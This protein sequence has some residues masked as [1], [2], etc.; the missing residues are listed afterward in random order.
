MP[1][2]GVKSNKINGTDPLI[3]RTY[4][5]IIRMVEKVGFYDA[6]MTRHII[7]EITFNLPVFLYD[8]ILQ[9]KWN[10]MEFL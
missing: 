7:A 4:N 6:S 2:K 5:W 9:L 10:M 8:M 3:T 1:K